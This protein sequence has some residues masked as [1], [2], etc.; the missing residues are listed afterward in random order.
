MHCSAMLV[1][2]S[3]LRNIWIK[4]IILRIVL[5]I[6]L[7][8]QPH[9]HGLSVV[10]WLSIYLTT[11]GLFFQWFQIFIILSMSDL[12]ERFLEE[13]KTFAVYWF[14]FFTETSLSVSS[15]IQTGFNDLLFFIGYFPRRDGTI[16][17]TFI[18]FVF[19]HPVLFTLQHARLVY[20]G[21]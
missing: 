12:E 13:T 14:Q 5:Q 10:P 19:F 21:Q 1:C 9:L 16:I 2:T 11:K 8:R 20:G 6:F 18:L 7:T 3:V 15:C 4:F 17:S